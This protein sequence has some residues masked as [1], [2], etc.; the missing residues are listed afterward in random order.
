[1]TFKR[2]C[3]QWQ[4][5]QIPNPVVG[6]MKDHN[7]DAVEARLRAPGVGRMAVG[8]IVRVDVLVVNDVL[9][10]TREERRIRVCRSLG[11]YGSRNR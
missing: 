1:M 6:A 2:V 4:L 8:A 9:R 3:F 11:S 5:G 7:D 10:W